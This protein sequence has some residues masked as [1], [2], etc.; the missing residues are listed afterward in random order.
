MNQ[1]TQNSVDLSNAIDLLVGNLQFG[2]KYPI[3][4]MNR[5]YFLIRQECGLTPERGWD[6]FVVL[7]VW[8]QILKSEGFLAYINHLTQ[9]LIIAAMQTKNIPVVDSL[10]IDVAEFIYKTAAKNGFAISYQDIHRTYAIMR[11]RP[12]WLQLNLLNEQ[13]G[14]V[15]SERLKPAVRYYS[16]QRNDTFESW[17]PGWK[18]TQRRQPN[19]EIGKNAIKQYLL[20]TYEGVP[21][22]I[23]LEIAEEIVKVLKRQ[24]IE[25]NANTV[26]THCASIRKEHREHGGTLVALP[27]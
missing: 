12:K 19:G 18:K 14:F 21:D 24:K 15:S 22:R 4:E 16:L 13:I 3:K 1:T 17:E 23:N 11:K 6:K 26:L 20:E 9:P 7:K 8:R 10:T 27:K 25:Y 5:S 2:A